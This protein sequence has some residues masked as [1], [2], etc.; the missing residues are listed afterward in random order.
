MLVIAILIVQ[1]FFI[2]ILGKECSYKDRQNAPEVFYINMDRSVDRNINM[3]NHLKQ[4]KLKF[5]RIR[6]IIPSEIYIPTDIQNTWQ[7]KWCMLETEESIP[8]KSI[9]SA[10]QSHILNGYNSIML[11]MCGRGN[12]K[13]T[14]KEL[15]CVISHLVAM[16]TAIYSPTATSRYA[17]IVEDDVYFPFDIDFD[18]LA[19]SAPTGFGS[20]I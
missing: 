2:I 5:Q 8:H 9:V 20:T 12:K 3:R 1:I 11:A 19:L 13:N 7:T 14:Q 15:G 10:N 16:R 6:G 4:L 18:A 17:L